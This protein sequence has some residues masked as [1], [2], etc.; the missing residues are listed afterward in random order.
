MEVHVQPEH[1]RGTAGKA[2]PSYREPEACSAL[3][4][5]WLELRVA[6]GKGFPGMT[7]CI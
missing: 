3:L 1:L 2:V 6:T 7:P 5:I 4:G